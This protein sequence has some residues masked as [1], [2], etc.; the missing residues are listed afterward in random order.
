VSNLTFFEGVIKSYK[1]TGAIAPSGKALAEKIT[2]MAELEDAKV[3][4]EFGAGTGAFTEVILRKKHPDAHF[5]SFE[6]NPDFV[7]AARKRCPTA[8]IYEESA[9][10]AGEILSASGYSHC[11]V[12]VSSLPWTLF[13]GDLQDRILNAAYDIIRPGGRFLT[14]AYFMSPYLSS[15]RRFLR[16]KL[17]KKFDNVIQS[18]HIWLNI[19]PCTV[20]IADKR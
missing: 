14:F 9:E 11:D 5:I 15:G 20:F 7:K 12:I 1:V 18:R 13:D 3:I 17:P 16:G 19:P 10:K 2:D 6:V 8:T 4:V